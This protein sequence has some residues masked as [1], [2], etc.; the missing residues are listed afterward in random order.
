MFTPVVLAQ[1]EA[2]TPRCFTENIAAGGLPSSCLERWPAVNLT[3]GCGSLA[4]EQ[5][6]PRTVP[7]PSMFG[8]IPGYPPGHWFASRRA[9]FEAGV[10]RQLR[11]GICGRA[12][13]GAESVVLSGGYTDDWDR[14][15]VILYTG[16]GG[17][18]H[19]T[20]EQVADQRLTGA[21]RALAYNVQTGQPVRVVRGA[22]A[23]S[24]WAPEE[25][26]RY[27]GL[28]RVDAYWKERGE[29]GYL[30]WRYQLIQQS[31]HNTLR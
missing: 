12:E 26:Y 2:L 16:R 3:M 15:D 18:D 21:N 27:D 29:A 23:T 30:I 17:R 22:G 1:A 25:G 5:F 28:Y 31:A 8:P 11:A 24:K 10:H 9:L 14:G 6:A 7:H 20:G 19:T 13:E 4:S